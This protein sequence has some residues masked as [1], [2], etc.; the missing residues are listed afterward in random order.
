MA[1]NTEKHEDVNSPPDRFAERQAALLDDTHHVLGD[2]YPKTRQLAMDN[3]RSI[4]IEENPR[5]SS[6]MP[7]VANSETS[8]PS[9]NVPPSSS[10]AAGISDNL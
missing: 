2:A 1:P 4:G 8:A 9:S 7:P 5:P 6:G 10:L 3:L